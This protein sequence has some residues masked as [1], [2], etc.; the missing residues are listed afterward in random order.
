MSDYTQLYDRLG[1]TFKDEDLLKTALTHAS[2]SSEKNYERLEFL[3][4]RVLGFVIAALL[5]KQFV[6]EPEGALARRFTNLV[7]Q[8]TLAEIAQDIGLPEYIRLSWGEK[9]S[10]G[11]YK[12]SLLSDCCESLL[13]AIYLDGGIEA[14]SQVIEK[15]WAAYINMSDID[16][17]DAKSLLQELVQGQGKPLP[18][19]KVEKVVGP[20]HNPTYTIE[21]LVEGYKPVKGQG[22]SKRLAEQAAATAMLHDLSEEPENG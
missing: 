9:K 8:E 20:S 18:V 15:F 21:V 12:E 2:K 14:A 11:H 22:P 19:Y 1:Y 5:Y 6:Q 7:R 16:K 10:R 3:G 4:D 13:A 17:K